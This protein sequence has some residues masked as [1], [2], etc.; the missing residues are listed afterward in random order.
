MGKLRFIYFIVIAFLFVGCIKKIDLSQDVEDSLD[1]RPNV[2]DIPVRECVLRSYSLEKKLNPM[3]DED[4]IFTIYGNRNIA[5]YAKSNIDLSNLIASFELE[6]GVATIAGITQL[7]GQTSNNYNNRLVFTLTSEDGKT[8]DYTVHLFPYTGLPVVT[9]TTC[10]ELEIK[11]K[12]TWLEAKMYIDGMGRFDNFEDSL[13]V[14]GRGNGSW[15]FPKKPF[16]AK[17]FNKVSVLGMNKHKRWCFLANY[18]DRTLLRNDL[19]LKL[20]QLADGL[21]WTPNGEFVDVIFNG[22]YKG[23][24]YLCEH[25][26]VDS[27]RVNINEIK[28]N[29][30]LEVSLTGGYLL[31]LDSYYDEVNKFKTEI[32]QWPVNLKSPDEDVCTNEH[33]SYIEDYY[34]TVERLLIEGEFEQLYDEYLDINSFVDYYLIQTLSGNTELQH[35]YSV[36]CYKKRN[37]KLYA[38]PLWDFDLSTYSRETGGSNNSSVWYKYLINDDRFKQKLKERFELLKPKI[39]DW[40]VTYLKE[41]ELYLS[42]SVAE[43]WKDWEIDT[44]Y[45]YNRL[46]GDET[47]ATYEEAIE[48]M[49]DMFLSRLSWMEEYISQLK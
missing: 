4:I 6:N 34:N 39:K 10:D 19:T 45:L 5:G 35:I 46:N 22:E 41:Q 48:R 25:I 18:R 2:E 33:L 49:K 1:S 47:F 3:L 40:A 21:E 36:Y 30:S 23:N 43:N 24:F 7:D 31:E 27:K 29:E 26:R 9:I 11:N 16:N 44:S 37:G 20:G 42:K 17:L 12:E 32:N 38:G 14:R 13:Y 8:S 15:K 28:T